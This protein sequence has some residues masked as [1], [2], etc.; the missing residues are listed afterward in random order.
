VF[1]VPV[2]PEA[3]RWVTVDAE[4]DVLAVARTFTSATR[5]LDALEA[6]RGDLR[7]QV[8]FAVDET[9]AFNDGIAGLLHSEGARVIPWDQISGTKFDLAVTASENVEIRPL[10]AP[11]VVIPHG[12]G[13]HKYV[14]DSGS[15]DARVSG[16]V[17]ESRLRDG[18]VIMTAA[19][20]DQRDQ[21]AAT[22]PEA[23]R[24]T[25]IVGDPTYDRIRACLSL[26]DQYRRA[27]GVRPGGRLTVL[28]STWGR[29]SLLGRHPD[30]PVR[31]LAELPADEHQVALIVHPN[32]WYGHGPW[33]VRSWLADARD[34]GLRLIPPD[35][36]WQAALI[37]ADTLIGDHGSVTVYGAAIGRPVLLASF[38]D[39]TVPGTPLAEFGRRAPRLDPDSALRPQVESAAAD[40]PLTSIAAGMFA[41]TGRTDLSDLLYSVLELPPPDGAARA[42]ALPDPH[43]DGGPHTVASYIVFTSVGGDGEITL[44]RHPAAAGAPADAWPGAVRHLCAGEHEPDRLLPGNASVLY[45]RGPATADDGRAWAAAALRGHPGAQLAAAATPDGC[46]AATRGGHDITAVT[47]APTSLAASVLYAALRADRLATGRLTARTGAAAHAL[48]VEVRP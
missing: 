48:E 1:R 37:A 6:F 17:P 41:T 25:V 36:G 29:G 20:P 5:L 30:L 33:Q 27:L 39:E 46:V 19:H 38:G 4:R 23:A 18:H 24:R 8:V 7:V 16:V 43:A 45:R 40:T 10:G 28:S 26:R 42:R 34:A 44:S 3:R 15:L 13:F 12:I 35:T 9:S 2:G 32:V 14:P 11:V 47:A 21:L 22:H 31:L